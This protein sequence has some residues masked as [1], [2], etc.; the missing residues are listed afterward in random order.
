MKSN[1]ADN[2]TLLLKILHFKNIF[3]KENWRFLN[4]TPLCFT[5]E[6]TRVGE[7]YIFWVNYP[8]K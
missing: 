1:D 7:E 5:E 3:K 8:F 4:K 2:L 6:A